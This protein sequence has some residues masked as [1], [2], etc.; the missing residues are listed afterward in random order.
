MKI[1]IDR[2]MIVARVY[3]VKGF[4]GGIVVKNPLA[5]AGDA[6]NMGSILG[7]GRSPGVGMATCSNN[8]CLG[9][10]MDKGAWW[11]VVHGVTKSQTM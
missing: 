4:P 5:N 11:A 9:N 10:S 2:G 7:L 3:Y 1:S 8:S 6:R